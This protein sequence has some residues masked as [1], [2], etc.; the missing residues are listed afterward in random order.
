MTISQNVLKFR[1]QLDLPCSDQPKLL[2]PNEASFYARFICEELSEF[3]KAHEGR[4]LVQAAD[5]IGDL[6]Y[7]LYG[8]SHMMGIPIDE[9]LGAIHRANMQKQ[10]G[11]SKRGHG[12]AIKPSNWVGPES[13]ILEILIKANLT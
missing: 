8:A 13:E 10:P 11:T 12:D 6:I 1:Q 9:V 2:E 4:D 7:L 5:A 3:L